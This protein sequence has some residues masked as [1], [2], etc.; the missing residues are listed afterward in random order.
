MVFFEDHCDKRFFVFFCADIMRSAAHLC[1][2]AVVRNEM[3]NE[4]A[5]AQIKLQD[6]LE[7][8]TAASMAKSEFLANMSH[9]L[10][11]PLN[12]VS[13][14]TYLGKS[15]NDM[16]EMHYCFSKI[17]EAADH[18]LGIIN[19][20]LD[21]SKIESGKF[22]LSTSEFQFEKMLRRAVNVV[23]FRAEEKQQKLNIY[24]DK[25]IPEILVGDELRFS[26]VI[27]NLAGNAVKFTPEK[28]S[29]RIGAYFMGEEDDI[30]T[31]KITVTDSG[32]GISPAHQAR[33]FDSF[34]Q[35]ESGATRKFGGTGLGLAIAKN[36]VEAMGGKIWLESELGEGATF[37][38]TVRVERG[39][40]KDSGFGPDDGNKEDAEQN[41]MPLFAG[42]RI[43]LAEDVEIN[44]EIVLTLLEPT[45][46]EF[47]C[48]E[49]GKEA[50]DLF[51]KSPE[52]YDLIFMDLQMPEMDGHEATQIIR[53][54][55]VPNAKTVP[56]IAMSANVFKE[57]VDRCF[58]SGM[59]WHIGKPVDFDELLKL[60]RFYLS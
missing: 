50:V 48:A 17:E 19:D 15:A 51:S 44:R 59:N 57:D 25:T 34:Q 55:D 20:I 30:C 37:A 2:N 16:D 24:I 8:A 22:A 26:Q 9:E 18:L 12:A 43:L 21:M 41:A 52:K 45:L 31:I 29:I 49:N 11:T 60:L 35:V 23:N 5:A 7:Q 32:I 53:A 58:A 10:R 39:E 46:L 54:L 56:V 28:G 47:D 27:T 40:K 42:R 6:A 13:G 38:F 4:I 3:E 14:M 1:V 33:L 36:I